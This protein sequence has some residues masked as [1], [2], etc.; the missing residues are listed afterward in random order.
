MLLNLLQDIFKN[1]QSIRKKNE[2]EALQSRGN[3]HRSWLLFFP[4]VKS[5]LDIE[6]KLSM[7]PSKKL[8]EQRTE[9]REGELGMQEMVTICEQSSGIHEKA[10]CMHVLPC[11]TAPPRD[12][13]GQ[14]QGDS[15][16]LCVCDWGRAI[17]KT[18]C[19]PL[20]LVSK[21]FL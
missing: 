20:L 12:I 10:D 9:L 11:V 16:A 21:D 17:Q 19:I 18:E 8:M 15:L 7:S 3:R 13:P 14:S 5:L 1:E 4:F 2:G 6:M